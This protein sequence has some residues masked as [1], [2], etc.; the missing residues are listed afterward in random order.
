VTEE[1]IKP[2][3]VI[4]VGVVALTVVIGLGPR[5]L[6]DAAG[7]EIEIL[8]VLK[9]AESQGFELDVGLTESLVA[10]RSNF[11]RV[12]VTVQS[13]EHAVVTA[14][15]DFDGKVG[16]TWVSSLGAEK[17]PFIRRGGEWQPVSGFAPVLTSIVKKLEARREGLQSGKWETICS[18]RSDGGESSELQTLLNVKHRRVRVKRWLIRSER[19]DVTVSEE[20]RVNGDLADRPVDD[21]GTRRLLLRLTPP[22]E[23]CFPDGIM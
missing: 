10:T 19:E 14:T 18:G 22:G 11:D 2:I 17:V 15:L 20:W 6:G 3:A 4:G 7:P 21:V 13:A 1:N 5:V 16:A 23:L 12:S 8:T 9:Q